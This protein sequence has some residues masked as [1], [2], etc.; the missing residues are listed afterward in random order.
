MSGKVYVNSRLCENFSYIP[1]END[2]I[3]VRGQGRFVYSGVLG[4]TKKS[5]SIITVGVYR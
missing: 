1:K 2:I 5:R 3:S 4:K